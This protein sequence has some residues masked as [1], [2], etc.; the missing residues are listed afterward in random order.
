MNWRMSTFIGTSEEKTNDLTSISKS[1]QT[2]IIHSDVI[3]YCTRAILSQTHEI[4]S[5]IQQRPISYIAY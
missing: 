4:K 5:K 1:E 3:H 2:I